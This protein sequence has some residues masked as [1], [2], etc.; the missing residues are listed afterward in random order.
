MKKRVSGIRTIEFLDPR[1]LVIHIDTLDVAFHL[2]DEK[3]GYRSFSFGALT[4]K[5]LMLIFWV[6]MYTP[7]SLIPIYPGERD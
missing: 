6:W 2:A 4:S 3:L 1:R 5:V 7:S